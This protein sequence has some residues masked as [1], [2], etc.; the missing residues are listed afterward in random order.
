M[1]V[2]Q[3]NIIQVWL[4]QYAALM[5]K[6]FH[7]TR[8]KV[9]ALVVQNVLPLVIIALSLLIA[10]SLQTVTDQPPL[11]LSP[12]LFFAKSQDNY[13][14][15]GGRQTNQTEPYIDTLFR[16][17][18]V[19]AHLLG[20]S[21][22]RS[23]ACY[24]DPSASFPC[25]R[26][27]TDQYHE[28]ECDHDCWNVTA[29]STDSSFCY[30]GTQTGSRVQNLTV[31]T[32]DEEL[33]YDSLTAYLLR[34]KAS[35]IEKRYG[36]MSFGHEREEIDPNVD[37]QNENLSSSLPFLAAHSAAKVWYSLK[38][39]HAMPAYLNTMNNAI[40]RA[41]LPTGSDP[42]AYGEHHLIIPRPSPFFIFL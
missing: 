31:N 19:G 40:L 37:T 25:S 28:C 42:S 13:M 17:C 30:N 41:N 2:Q 15:V 23:S 24:F 29:L 20:N 4:S 38:G 7:Y 14:F 1:K 32:T 33:T 3:L 34:S 39:Y 21:S 6:R 36:G 16:P 18:G 12:S 27:P 8:R 22:D 9:T 5:V 26:F 11:E 10:N 35:F